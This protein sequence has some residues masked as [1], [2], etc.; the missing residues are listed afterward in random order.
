MSDIFA[1]VDEVMKQDRL[2]QIWAEYGNLII[3]FIIGVIVLTAVVSGYKSWNDS[4]KEK[5]T[6][7]LSTLVSDADF[8][9]NV[10]L[11]T[12][13][14][15][16]DVRAIALMGAGAAFLDGEDAQPG[17][18]LEMYKAVQGDE[19]VDESYRGLA[20]LM[21]ARLSVETNVEESMAALQAVY[22]DEKSLWRYHAAIE[23][24]VLAAHE[25]GD[26]NKARTYLADVAAQEAVLPP[27]LVMRARSLDHL[28]ALRQDEAK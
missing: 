15:K 24:A 28:Y 25:G 14:L 8:P 16:G 3:A 7:I 23:L 18:A 20:A 9:M 6:E 13:E 10:D 27:G 5:Q 12:L 17:K 22:D 21:V 11:E 1:E 26:L 19:S 4:V 2:E